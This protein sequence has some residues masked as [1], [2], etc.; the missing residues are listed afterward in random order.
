MMALRTPSP[1]TRARQVFSATPYR[2]VR[3]RYA[4]CVPLIQSPSSI[5]FWSPG[6]NLRESTVRYG[7]V[8]VHKF[9]KVNGRAP[10][11][12]IAHSKRHG[13]CDSD[14]RYWPDR[15]RRPRPTSFFNLHHTSLHPVQK[16]RRSRERSCESQ[17][18]PSVRLLTLPAKRAQSA[19]GRRWLYLGSGSNLRR[20]DREGLHSVNTRLANGG[21]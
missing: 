3:S 8:Q 16:T 13:P 6:S 20:Y 18:H 15:L 1:W 10:T 19:T 9:Y 17:C 5:W 7:Y 14:W 2:G 11:N 21:C 12:A 4:H